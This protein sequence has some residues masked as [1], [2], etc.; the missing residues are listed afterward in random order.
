[1]SDRIIEKSSRE[2]D[3]IRAAGRVVACVH[4]RMREMIAPGRSTKDLDDE[5]RRII[6]DAGGVPTFLGY[7][8]GGRPRFPGAICAS[9]NEELVHGIPRRSRK[10]RSGDIVSVDVGCTLDGW[11]GDAA[12]TYGTGRISKAARELL[13]VTERCLAL[14]IE[15]C[16]PGGRLYDLARA[17]QGPAE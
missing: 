10:L 13:E 9:V 12:W 16:R 7:A 2:I 1:M 17:V 3:K 15:Q 6:A 14:A 11:V 8:P 5:A 4:A